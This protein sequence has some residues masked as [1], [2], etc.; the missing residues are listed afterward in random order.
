MLFS[1]NSYKN[2]RDVFFLKTF[3]S[4]HSVVKQRV[5]LAL[6][7]YQVFIIFIRKTC[8]YNIYPNEPHVYIGKL[9]FAGVY[10]FFLFLLQNIDCGYPQ[11]P[12]IYVLSKN[13]KNIQIFQLNIFNFST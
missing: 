4:F 5:I 12:T 11:L 7:S 8:P 2:D 10:L 3:K 13:K 9:G 6:V 1:D